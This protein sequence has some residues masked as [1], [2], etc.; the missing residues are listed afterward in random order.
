MAKRCRRPPPAR[1]DRVASGKA[2]GLLNFGHQ[3]GRR[4][5]VTPPPPPLTA[6][7]VEIPASLGNTGSLRSTSSAPTGPFGFPAYDTAPQRVLP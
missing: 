6:E 4:P 1:S 7:K 2:E 5:G 3:A